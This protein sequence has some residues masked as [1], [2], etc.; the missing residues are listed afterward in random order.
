MA[1]SDAERRTLDALIDRII[2]A[3]RWP[4]ARVLGVL[5]DVELLLDAEPGAAALAG[6]SGGLRAL[7]QFALHTSGQR[8]D[9]LPA[10]AQDDILVQVEAGTP[11][12]WPV[13]PAAFFA[14][15]CRLV[16][17]AYYGIAQDDGAGQATPWSMVGFRDPC[18]DRE[19]RRVLRR[20]A[21]DVRSTPPRALAARYDVIVIGAGAGGSVVAALASEAGRT[22]LVLERGEWLS[23]AAI[24]HDHLR[25]QRFA[26]HGTNAGPAVSERRSVLGSDGAERAVSPLDPA[27]QNNAST[28]GGGT[29]VFGA[30]AWRFHPQDFAMASHYGVP[31]GSSLVDWPI[32][33]EDLEPFYERAEW[34]LGVSGD[35]DAHPS[36]GWRR[37]GY[38]M[39]ALRSGRAVAHLEAGARALGWEAGAVPFLINSQPRGGRAACVGCAHC[40]G[41]ACPTD[42]KSGA[43]NTVLR[44]ALA[45]G[46]THLATRTHALRICS[47][48]PGSVT[49]VVV[50]W[51]DHDG[52]VV[53]RTIEADHVV[54]AAGAVESGRLLLNSTA[55]HSPG[56]LGNAHDQV[57]RHLQ[58]H[59]YTGALGRF[60]GVVQDC[61]GPG[62][63]VATRM[64]AHDLGDAIGGGML[65]NDFVKMPVA[66]W[67]LALPPGAPRWG[68]RGKEVMRTY[69]R[70]IHVTG[71]VQE[72][73]SPESRLRLS[74]QIYD[75]FG[76]PVALFSG[77]V[78]PETLRTARA[79]RAEAVRWLDAAGAE[80]VWRQ[81]LPPA[82]HLSGGQHQAGT[83]RMGADP[84]TS[85]TDPL[86]RVHGY[87]NLWV[88]DGS[89][90][91]TNGGVNPVLTI[92]ALAYRM[93]ENLLASATG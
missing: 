8:F 41:F 56:G 29:R 77:R 36:A 48:R 1:L 4:G 75:R 87:R 90:H 18:E 28:V 70:T 73:P 58:G 16:A 61:R 50:A 52:R 9:L 23:D 25:N 34:E 79:L 20:D 19:A 32:S 30:Q 24:G 72:V 76:M 84:R 26:R 64:F 88:A 82:D 3:D 63:G 11:V 13:S 49:G 91:V 35:A 31:E 45:T 57:G 39:P 5:A 33:Y 43:H 2:P 65:A 51:E 27:F 42:A 69:T 66:F 38:P 44:R 85:V 92:F 47:A 74:R 55:A 21:D 80:E 46:R 62:P 60:S 15:M 81:P 10:R 37:R 7:D 71:P 14:S 53:R 17:D 93:A 78:H 59:V 83:A 12:G 54:V 68:T 22:V 86:G 67:A 6:T 40:V 89:V